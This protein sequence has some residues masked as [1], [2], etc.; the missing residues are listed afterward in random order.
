LSS[1]LLTTRLKVADPTALTAL[2]T[3]RTRLG[4]ESLGGLTREE[5]FLFEIDAPVEAALVLVEGLV[6]RTN[7]FHNPNKHVFRIRTEEDSSEAGTG[8][9]SAL[10]WTPGDGEELRDSVW[11]HAGA[12]NV[13][14]V[15]HAWLWRFVPAPGAAQDLFHRQVNDSL[16]LESRTR[17][18]LV[19]PAYQ[20]SRLYEGRPSV[21]DTWAALAAGWPTPAES[22]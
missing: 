3:L 22:S 14:A 15:R 18:F 5:V 4:F 10:I 8:G 6:R 9:V 13:T 7:L 16:R 1:I 17:G 19:N 11:H 2:G 12:T 20:E 21:Y